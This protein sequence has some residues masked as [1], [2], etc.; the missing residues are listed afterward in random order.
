MSLTH[1]SKLKNIRS[2]FK[3]LPSSRGIVSCRMTSQPF[4]W[5]AEEF[6][7][8]SDSHMIFIWKCTHLS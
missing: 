4:P 2:R 8:L 6:G 7:F 5:V 3:M 1:V